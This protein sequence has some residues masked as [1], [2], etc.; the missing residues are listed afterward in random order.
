MISSLSQRLE[1]EVNSLAFTATETVKIHQTPIPVS[2]LPNVS[3]PMDELWTVKTALD[4]VMI[5]IGSCDIL[6]GL[7]PY[8]R[9]NLC[10]LHSD[11]FMLRWVRSTKPR[12]WMMKMSVCLQ[13]SGR[14]DKDSRR[15][16]GMQLKLGYGIFSVSTPV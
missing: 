11:A 10:T 8:N 3:T 13:S 16:P 12:P 2:R 15:L 1:A 14:L 7:M 6:N 5:F 9:V 4:L